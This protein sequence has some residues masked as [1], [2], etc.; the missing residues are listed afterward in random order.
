MKIIRVFTEQMLLLWKF[1]GFFQS[2][3]LRL[4]HILAFVL[5][6]AQLVKVARTP[7]VD[8]WHIEL[9]LVLVPFVCIFL[10]LSLSK[11]GLRYFFPY[12]WG[13]TEQLRKDIPKVLQGGVAPPRPGGL[14]GAVQGLGFLCFF[15]STMLG[16]IWYLL[17]E[18][19]TALSVDFLD[20]HRYFGYALVFYVLGHGC[21]ALRQFSVW[22]KTQKK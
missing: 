13:D 1:L 4:W 5:V 16:L 19:H 3:L 20:Y 6:M 12:L 18:K 14:P 7:T 21:M 17:W 9:G 8:S 15:A 11:R 22:K 10:G 2:P